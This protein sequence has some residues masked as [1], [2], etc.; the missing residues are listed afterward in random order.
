MLLS[1]LLVLLPVLAIVRQASFL[2][3]GVVG[4]ARR[5]LIIGGAGPRSGGKVRR[6][7]MGRRREP[8]E[9]ETVVT[10]GVEG[11]EHVVEGGLERARRARRKRKD[12][13]VVGSKLTRRDWNPE[14][15]YHCL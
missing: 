8:P 12:N 2:R 7:R 13:L 9:G 15:D 14:S 4:V 6:W 3:S 10:D 11:R 1:L 5:G